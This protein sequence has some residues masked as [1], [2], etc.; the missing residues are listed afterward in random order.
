MHFD[1]QRGNEED[2]VVAGIAGCREFCG[3]VCLAD[4]TIVG[5]EE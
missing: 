1:Q 2:S 3:E 5:M 4:G